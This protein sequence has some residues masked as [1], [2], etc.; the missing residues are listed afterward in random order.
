MT[1]WIKGCPQLKHFCWKVI[2]ERISLVNCYYKLISGSKTYSSSSSYELSIYADKF[3]F[4][5]QRAVSS[6]IFCNS[7]SII[8]T[9]V[10][11]SY[12]VR[13]TLLFS[14]YYSTSSY[15]FIYSFI[16]SGLIYVDGFFVAS[17]LAYSS[18][19]VELLMLSFF[20]GGYSSFFYSYT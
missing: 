18:L 17:L 2:K 6:S 5:Y 20:F 14:T 16:F 13:R 11:S 7:S 19:C 3:A 4:F 9:I 12:L 10:Y 8:L 15:V 1:S